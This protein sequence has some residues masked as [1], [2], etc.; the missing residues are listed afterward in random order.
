MNAPY[1]WMTESQDECALTSLD[2]SVHWGIMIALQISEGE[3][4][5]PAQVD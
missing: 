5:K 3:N 1:G 2:G 4:S